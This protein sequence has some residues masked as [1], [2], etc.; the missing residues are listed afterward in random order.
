M[1]INKIARRQLDRRFAQI[2]PKA[3]F[4]RPPSGWLRAIRESLGMTAAQLGARL[5]VS[6]QA[7][8]NIEE[9]EA[10]DAITLKTLQRMAGAMDCSLYYV[11]VPSKGLEQMVQMRA[12]E[13]ATEQ[14]NRADRTMK[15][16]NQALLAEDRQVQIDDLAEELV[17]RD[18]RSLWR[19]R[20]G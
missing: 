9:S 10:R 18:I 17:Q 4:T 7:V 20:T 16:E 3:L 15:L 13:I 19:R 11:V 5:G 6:K 14:V 12:H 1:Q 8:L 2:G